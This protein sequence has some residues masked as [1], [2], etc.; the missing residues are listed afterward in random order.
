M[1]WFTGTST[2][3]RYTVGQTYSNGNGSYVANADGS[4]TNVKS[5]RTDV[6]S[7][8]DPRVTFGGY[9]SLS[10]GSTGPGVSA[11]HSG[12]GASAGPGAAK[13]ASTVRVSGYAEASASSG[14]GKSAGG[15]ITYFKQGTTLAPL[16]GS[17]GGSPGVTTVENKPLKR[18][19]VGGPQEAAG[20]ISDIGWG[21]STTGYFPVPGSDMKERMEDDIVQELMW[22]GRNYIAPQFGINQLPYPEF[23]EPGTHHWNSWV[24]EWQPNK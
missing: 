20:A 9:S 18:I 1:A 12:G 8:R 4:F 15:S 11:V 10:S 13:T 22:F 14:V 7:S 23:L 5:G 17:P 2:G 6:G 19:G 21:V 3:D 24:N 16:T